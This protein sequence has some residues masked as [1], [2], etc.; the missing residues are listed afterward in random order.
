MEP[1]L[2]GEVDPLKAEA[3]GGEQAKEQAERE[4]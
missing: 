2:P 4:A 3:L 1:V